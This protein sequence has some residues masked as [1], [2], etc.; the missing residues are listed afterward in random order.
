[1]HGYAW[2]DYHEHEVRH[3]IQDTLRT[4]PYYKLDLEKY[5]HRTKSNMWPVVVMFFLNFAHIVAW[6][7]VFLVGF[8]YPSHIPFILL[9][10]LPLIYIV[11]S[12]PCHFMVYAKL[13][14]I[15]KHRHELK[16][17]DSFHFNE[18]DKIAIDRIHVTCGLD[19]AFLV[20]AWK[21]IK[22]YEH[23]FVIPYFIDVMRARFDKI[24]YANPLSP[25]G[26]IV[27]SF[28]INCLAYAIHNKKNKLTAR[29]RK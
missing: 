25:Q 20:D 21:V 27:L 26:L 7:Y 9:V 2:M 15:K 12:M 1:M 8:A 3:G 23:L 11:Q 5:M 6:L 29:S 16:S 17:L 10:L 22:Y 19:K 18:D 4:H 13:M 24:S 28:I 14:F